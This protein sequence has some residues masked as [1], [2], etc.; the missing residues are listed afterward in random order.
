MKSSSRK[1]INYETVNYSRFVLIKNVELDFLCDLADYTSSIFYRQYAY[2]F[3]N[4]VILAIVI[5]YHT[6]YRM[7][8]FIEI[9]N[10]I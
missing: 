9:R 8:Y 4:V 2:I 6:I 5:F 10:P 7:S 3:F 1:K